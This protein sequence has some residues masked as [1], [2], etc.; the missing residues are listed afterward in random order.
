VVLALRSFLIL[1]EFSHRNGG[2]LRKKQKNSAKAEWLAAMSGQISRCRHVVHLRYGRLS[3]SVQPQ[4]QTS[5][6]LWHD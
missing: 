2:I 3:D 5:A 4:R 6:W 1:A